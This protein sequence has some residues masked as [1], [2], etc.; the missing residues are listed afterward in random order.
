MQGDA[1]A[2]AVED[3]GAEAVGADLVFGLEHFAAVVLHGFEGLVEAAVDEKEALITSLSA[4][5][6]LEYFAPFVL[7]YE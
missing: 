1:V 5:S 2:F 7:M 3:D 6:A 4:Q